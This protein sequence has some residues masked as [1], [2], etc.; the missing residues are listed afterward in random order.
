MPTLTFATDW[1]AQDAYEVRVYDARSGSRLVTY[2]VA[3]FGSLELLEAPALIPEQLDLRA[4]FGNAWAVYR[5]EPTFD[6]EV[7]FTR[8]ASAIVT[9]TTWHPSQQVDHNEDGLVTLTFRVDGLEEITHWLAG[10]AGFVQVVR[11]AELRARV[12]ERWR[13]WIALDGESQRGGEFQRGRR[14]FLDPRSHSRRS[15]HPVGALARARGVSSRRATRSGDRGGTVLS[16]PRTVVRSGSS[17]DGAPA[18]GYTQA[19]AQMRQPPS[20]GRRRAGR[21]R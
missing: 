8:D 1:P 5:G 7:R 10:W 19:Q 15:A 2:R 17:G 16:S 9:E 3:R 11:R 13:S 21:A 14:L 6:F 12:V 20:A 4:Y 18:I